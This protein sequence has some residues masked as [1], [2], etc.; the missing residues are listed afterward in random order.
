[1]S[2]IP[3]MSNQCILDMQGR[4]QTNFRFTYFELGI[5]HCV[6]CCQ[7]NSIQLRQG[8]KHKRKNKLKPHLLT[9]L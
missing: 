6:Q 8:K 9:L 2:V 1:M 5:E 7:S 4:L 3:R